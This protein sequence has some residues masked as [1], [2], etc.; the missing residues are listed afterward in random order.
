MARK[1]QGVL[2]RMLERFSHKATEWAGSSWAFIIA[3]LI[4]IVWATTGPIFKFS[5]TWQLVINT[6]TTIVTFLM[7]FLIQRTQNKD[8]LAI[9]LKLNEIVAALDGASNRLIDVEDL[10]EE[11]IKVLHRHYG[12]LAGMAKRDEKITM[13]HSIEEAEERHQRK[14]KKARKS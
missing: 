10:S 3:L 5:D 9:H 11:E 4:I 6:G 2:S 8:A 7:V 13:S 14:K 1:K 12:K